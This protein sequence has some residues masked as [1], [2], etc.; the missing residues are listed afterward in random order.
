M[1]GSSKN[2]IMQLRKSVSLGKNFKV[3]FGDKKNAVVPKIAQAVM[4]KYMSF[5]KPMDKESFKVKF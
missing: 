3:E 5:R 1:K 2:I 4:N